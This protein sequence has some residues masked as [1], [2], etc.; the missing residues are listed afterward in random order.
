MNLARKRVALATGSTLVTAALAGLGWWLLSGR[1]DAPTA[2]GSGFAPAG[3]L[4]F[5]LAPD[6]RTRHATA[7]FDV[8]V[9]TNSLG[10]RGPEVAVP[11][12]SDVYRVLALGDSFSFGWGV[13][14]DDAWP[15]RMAR[16]LRAADGR[17]VEVVVAGVPGWSPPQQFVFLEQRGFDL[18][19]DLVLWQ[20]CTNDLIEM[21]RLDLSLDARRL[22]V[23]VTAEPPLSDDLREDW[24]AGF[25]RLGADE[26]QRVLEEYRA[27][28]VDPALRGIIRAADGERRSAAGTAPPGPIAG[29]AIEDVRRGL[30]SGPDF[31]LRFLDHMLSAARRACAERGIA[32]RLV[33]AKARSRPP[34][35]GEPDGGV[36]ALQ[37]WAA[38]QVP[39]ALDTGG[40][41]SE[42]AA[43]GYFFARDP[44]WTPAAQPVVAR[45]VALW[46]AG[47]AEL[48]LSP[49]AGR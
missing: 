15:A 29:L 39:R 17:S 31:G 16:E 8:E 48:G 13:E 18:Q 35:A 11:K 37:A 25:E 36:A 44:H 49:G 9:E 45:A 30:R 1:P 33:L 2:S 38:E 7:D 34:P 10:L 40:L 28:R 26:R 4:G 41:L 27:G 46:L 32:L 21:E 3:P 6:T 5:A 47:D 20:L 12:P 14:L 19:P 23:A 24:L 43:E 42:G 22:P